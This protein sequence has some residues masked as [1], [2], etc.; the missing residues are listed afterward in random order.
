MV[1]SAE[2]LT[3]AEHFVV[4]LC[5]FRFVLIESET[6]ANHLCKYE[7]KM[8]TASTKKILKSLFFLVIRLLVY[9]F[10]QY[11]EEALLMIAFITL[12]TSNKKDK[13]KRFTS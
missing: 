8:K 1:I 12:S 11:Y 9:V 2:N 6:K 4:L 7:C 5:Y 13:R 10:E 3:A